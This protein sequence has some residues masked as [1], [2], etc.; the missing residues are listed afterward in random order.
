DPRSVSALAARPARRGS[1]GRVV[2]R[3]VVEHT[4]EAGPR[5]DVRAQAA[6]HRDRRAAECVASGIEAGGE[7]LASAG[8]E[9]DRALPPVDRIAAIVDHDVDAPGRR[10]E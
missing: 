3:A 10:I 6:P 1:A 2:E 7:D 8:E 9:Q 5:L 4:K